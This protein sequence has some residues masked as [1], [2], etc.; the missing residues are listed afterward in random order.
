MISRMVRSLAAVGV[1]VAFVATA[2]SVVRG[3]QPA[4]VPAAKELPAACR[5]AKSEFHPLGQAD[6]T[7]AKSVLLAALDKLDKRLKL[8]G[9][10]GEAWRKYLEVAALREQLQRRQ[11]PDKA[12]L[13]KI[14]ARFNSGHDGL[15]LVWFLDTERALQNYLATMGAVGNA[16]IRADFEQ[17]LDKLAAS[18]EAYAAKPTTENALV[19]GES[20]RWLQRAQQVP[21]LVRAVEANFVRPNVLGQISPVVLGAGIAEHVDE[22]M[23]VRDCILGTDIYGTAHVFGQTSVEL[24]P[25]ADMGVFDTLFFGKT[26]SDNVG[27]HGPVTIYST[28]KTDMAARKRLWVTADGLS[29]YPSD[30]NAVTAVQIND[31]RSNR[32]RGMIERMAWKRAGK[33]QG[34]AESIASRHAEQRLNERIDR[35]GDEA[36]ERAN[37]SYVE[38]YQRPF[39]ERKLFPQD[40]RFSTTQQ[41]VCLV[42]LQAGGDKLGAPN[43]PPSVTEGA[44]MSLC[45]HESAVNNLAFD[46]LAGRTIYEEKVQAAVKDALGRLPDKMKGDDDGK[47]WAI[48]FAARQPISVTLVDGSFKVTIRGIRFCKGQEVH[49]DPMNISATY[50][51]EKAPSGFKA[52]RQGDIQVFPPDFV[53]GKQL[54]GRQQVIRKLLEKRFAKIFESEIIGEGL[55]LPGKW[56]AAGKML[57]IQ[58]VC[59]DGWLVIAWKRAAATAPKLASANQ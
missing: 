33:Q 40:I 26:L 57:P 15:D 31:I 55:E 42:A 16:E 38:K 19:I 17:R 1:F 36:L 54:G 14:R 53:P 56:K 9:S 52:V 35:Q 28:A 45:L 43:D 27:Y 25:N 13:A 34:T 22:T 5:K 30:S 4:G 32:G 2:A 59:R 20:L 12:R 39:T 3:G 23:P 18:L 11:G 41:A 47:P 10:N 51:I 48:T 44:E 6:V 37:R 29:S 21:E 46:A 58:L 7:Q 8:D 49:N 24:A 50:K